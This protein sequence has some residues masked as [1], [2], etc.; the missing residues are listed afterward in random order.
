[1][2]IPIRALAHETEVERRR[3][4]AIISHPDA[5]KT[6]LDGEAPAVRRGDQAR[7]AGQ[8][9]A[10]PAHHPLGLDGDRARARHFG[11]HLG[12]DLR[13]RRPRVQPARHAR[14]RGFLRGHLPHAHGGRFGRH[15]D[16]RR[17]GHRGAHPQAVRGVPAAR[18]PDH[19]LHQQARPREP[20]PVRPDRRDREDAGAR[21]RAG[22]LAGRA[23]ARLRRHHRRRDRRRAPARRRCRHHRQAA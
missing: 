7:R 2:N 13:V 15:G 6:T 4:F 3:T 8:G 18:H 12:D 5:G 10:R 19:H 17:Q 23:R 14:P 16:R 22:H 9:Q 20:R 21:H 1:M 11:G